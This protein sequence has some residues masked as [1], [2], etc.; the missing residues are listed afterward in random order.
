MEVNYVDESI[1]TRLAGSSDNC[2]RGFNG[3]YYDNSI[4]NGHSSCSKHDTNNNSGNSHEDDAD[5]IDENLINIFRYKFT[6]DFTDELFKFSKIHQYDN[7]KDFKEAWNSWVEANQELVNDEIRRLDNL[8]YNGDS[9]DK[10]YKS[11]RYYFRKKSTEKKEPIKRRIYIGSQKEL[12]DAMDEHIR[13]SIRDENFKP[14]DS[15]DVFCKKNVDLL[16]NEVTILC[17]TGITNSDI[18]KNKI[19]KTYKNRYFLVI[20][21]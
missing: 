2:I 9:M 3:I 6:N 7:R 20:K 11:A 12:L 5:N 19:K 14:S 4:D 18:I 16:K 10:M 13:T 21:K 8:G 15:F 1:I 17:R